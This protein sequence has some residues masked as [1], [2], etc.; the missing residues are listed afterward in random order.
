ML[1]VFQWMMPSSGGRSG[2]SRGLPN[3]SGSIGARGAFLR[4]CPCRATAAAPTL[5]ASAT[6]SPPISAVLKIIV[7]RAECSAWQRGYMP[8][9][10]D[11]QGS[12]LSNPLDRAG[13]SREQETK[14]PHL[15]EPA[16]PDAL[17]EP[18]RTRRRQ[19]S[20]PERAYRPAGTA[21]P[22][23]ACRRRGRRRRRGF[24]THCLSPACT[25]ENRGAP[26][27]IAC[28]IGDLVPDGVGGRF[29]WATTRPRISG[30]RMTALTGS[31]HGPVLARCRRRA[32]LPGARFG[33]NAL[34]SPC[35]PHSRPA[36]RRAIPPSRR[37]APCGP[38]GR[39]P[40]RARTMLSAARRGA[41]GDAQQKPNCPRQSQPNLISLQ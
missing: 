21:G 17:T 12:V 29:G 5:P 19:P 23:P 28:W 32:R 16:S 26:R 33:I 40:G 15:T 18:R 7:R 14:R 38:G 1:G 31:N 4:G 34:S 9:R 11:T 37:P 27:R 35:R 24:I 3:C 6:T 39:W 30:R 41:T 2:G 36:G 22:H 20:P 13:L 25:R 8:S 10:E